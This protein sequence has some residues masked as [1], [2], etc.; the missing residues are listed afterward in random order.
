[1]I[2]PR[3]LSDLAAYSLQVACIAALGGSLP[4]LF[5]IHAPGVRYAYFRALLALCVA[6]PWLQGRPNVVVSSLSAPVATV[7]ANASVPGASSVAQPAQAAFPW[8][9][10]LIVVLL[11]GAALRLIWIG[12]GL[13]RLRRLRVAARTAS[14]CAD[15]VEIAELQHVIG[16]RADVRYI[17][18]LSQP[19]TFGWWRP[20]VLLP[21]RLR[22]QPDHIQRAV[23]SHE[24]FHVQRKDWVW[25]LSEE[26][27]R[28]MLWFHPAVWWLVSRVQLAREEVVDELAVLAIGTRRGYIE[29]LLAFAD[30]TPLAPA[31]A[32]ARRRHLFQRVS[33]VSK[34]AVMSARRI[35]WSSAIMGLV[36]SAGGWY[37]VR[38]FPLAAAARDA[39]AA[40]QLPGADLSRSEPGPIERR[41]KPIT[42]ENPLP[43][44]VF[45]ASPRYPLEAATTRGTL[46]N[47]T[48][49]ITV[50]ESG[51]VA[52]ARGVAISGNL[53]VD[54]SDRIADARGVVI[55]VAISGN[56]TVDGSDRVADARGVA[57][58]R[59]LN[60][61]G[62]TTEFDQRATAIFR[63]FVE[64]ATDAVVRWQYDPPVNG[65]VSIRVTFAFSPGEEVRL[66]E[67][68][69]FA[70]PRRVQF[71]SGGI[72]GGIVG[73]V[74]GGIVGGLA[75]GGDVWPP[76]PPPPPPPAPR[77]PR[78]VPPPPP[79]PPDRPGVVVAPPPPPPPP[80]WFE[81]A[82]YLGDD[83][84]VKVKNVEPFYP[85]IAL[86]AR[87]Q[88]TVVIDAR[89]GEDG[90]VTNARLVRSEPLLNQSAL[91]AVFQWVFAPTIVNGRPVPVVVT[92]AVAF[93]LPR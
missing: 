22:D 85:P 5:R 51:R 63:A 29:A 80:D 2:S 77:A 3:L 91:D 23:L 64:S 88:G 53:T 9:T 26:A 13:V 57:I 76:P 70:A 86:A 90:H 30:E 68:E 17:D 39:T 36:V 67:H 54:G 72:D 66:V 74:S 71:G 47:V 62:I 52:E 12:V 78:A 55:S 46:L 92:L 15:T 59:Q 79:P 11:S 84:P 19:V 34:A 8:L 4:A 82:R 35:V 45:A 14:P 81:G 65:P 87:K 61:A 41:A 20:L 24:L 48:L 56:L 25:L 60:G 1:M 38:A 50:D 83:L 42:P 69:G 49:I 93:N 89:I 18:G 27:V 28:T 6:L 10:T 7:V 40:P 44:R 37:A 33:R 73:G 43:R 16:T 58:T 32:F 75:A 31:A 21:A